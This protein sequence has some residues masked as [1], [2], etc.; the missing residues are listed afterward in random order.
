MSE[1]HESDA[2]DSGSVESVRLGPHSTDSSAE[3][4][5]TVAPDTLG[6]NDPHPLWSMLKQAA[7][8]VATMMSY[9]VMQF[10]DGVMVS[11]IGK[12]P[13]YLAAHGNGALATFWPL[14]IG[15]GLIGMTNT[16]AAQHI[17]AGTERKAAAYAWN[18]V[19]LSVAFWL[20]LLPYAFAL[21]ALFAWQGHSGPLLELESRFAQTML[22][23]SVITLAARGMAQF[24]Y[25]VQRPGIVLVSAVAGNIVNFGC[26]VV[27]IFGSQ[28]LGVPALGVPGAAIGTMLGLT[29]ELVIPLAVFLSRGMNE[30][31]GTRAPW[32]F[33]WPHIKD[34]ARTGWPTGL[35]YGSEMACWMVFMVFLA[36]RF[37]PEQHQASWIAQRYMQISFMPAVGVSFAVTAI[38]GK[39][40]GAGRPDIAKQRAWL[41]IRCAMVYMGVCAVVML[42]FR[43]QLAWLFI[44]GETSPEKAAEIVAA[45]GNVMIVAAVFQVF[46]GLGITIV[47][48]LR[49]AGDTLWPGLMTVVLSWTCIVGGGWAMTVLAPQL[50]VVGPWMGAGFYIVTLGAFLGWRFAS[51]AW[52]KRK[53]LSESVAAY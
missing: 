4:G 40:L 29:V 53:L 28:K 12:D 5:E 18:A 8:S 42:A 16:Y 9:T 48:V 36:G 19:W 7:P 24:F 21:P 26:N 13:I 6:L 10:V 44:E 11:H 37:G 45:A 3:P 25:G 47:G 30:R 33:S 23:G 22:F 39:C 17:G 34:L 50:G 15:M 35:M 27:L 41:G 14:S 32:R 31:F 20:L 49:G 46:D 43:H 1:Q 52:T 38:V 51:G 2:T